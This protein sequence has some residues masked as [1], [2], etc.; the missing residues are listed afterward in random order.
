MDYASWMG[1]SPVAPQVMDYN[2]FAPDVTGGVTPAPVAAPVPASFGASANFSVAGWLAVLIV[3][4]AAYRY[5][6]EKA[7]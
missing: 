3:G 2:R 1:Y 5:L 7:G 6:W 4:L